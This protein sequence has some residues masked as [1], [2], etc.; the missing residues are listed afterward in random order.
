MNL[1]NINSRHNF[2]CNLWE[3]IQIIHSCII[4]PLRT[5][6]ER[7]LFIFEY[8]CESWAQGMR[9]QVLLK[10]K[11]LFWGDL[12]T[13][14][15]Q[16]TLLYS[17]FTQWSILYFTNRTHQVDYRMKEKRALSYHFPLGFLP[18]L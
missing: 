11:F 2:L 10:Y 1:I 13:L 7:E 9:R 8:A 14:C 12:L 18:P 15:S 6:T 5:S 16:F 3:I 17:V 4:Q